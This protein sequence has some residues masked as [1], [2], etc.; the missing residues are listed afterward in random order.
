MPNPAISR[1]SFVTFLAIFREML[2]NTNPNSIPAIG[3]AA[4][5]FFLQELRSMI[6]LVPNPE[7]LVF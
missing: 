5:A 3:L 1:Y 6:I 2:Q 7:G 4:L